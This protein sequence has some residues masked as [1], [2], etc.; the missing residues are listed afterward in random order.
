MKPLDWILQRLFPK[1]WDR[2]VHR[3]ATKRGLT[4]E[5]VRAK[6][7][8]PTVQLTTSYRDEIE[9]GRAIVAA[10]EKHAGRTGYRLR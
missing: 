6:L 9:L 4:D 3:V 1:T 10:L 5:Q 8:Q 7:K 2:A